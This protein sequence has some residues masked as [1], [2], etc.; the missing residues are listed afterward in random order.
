VPKLTY[1]INIDNSPLEL[2]AQALTVLRVQDYA[3]QKGL[4]FEEIQ[5]QPQQR[6]FVLAIPL[7]ELN[8]VLDECSSPGSSSPCKRLADDRPPIRFSTSGSRR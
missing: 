3:R 2:A 4:A 6:R 8:S 7:D 5:G 1:S